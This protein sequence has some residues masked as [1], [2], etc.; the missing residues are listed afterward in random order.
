[1]T[2]EEHIE[3]ARKT[4][5]SYEDFSQKTGA[6]IFELKDTSP[7]SQDPAQEIFERILKQ[8]EKS[9]GGILP[10]WEKF[11]P[12]KDLTHTQAIISLQLGLLADLLVKP[13]L[14]ESRRAALQL[15]I[16]KI[17]HLGALAASTFQIGDDIA[18]NP[19]KGTMRDIPIVQETWNALQHDAK[20]DQWDDS[21]SKWI[22][23]Q[24]LDNLHYQDQTK[25]AHLIQTLD[26][27]LK[28]IGDKGQTLA[29]WAEKT[30]ERIVGGKMTSAFKEEIGLIKSFLTG[31]S[32]KEWGDKKKLLLAATV[33][34]SLLTPA[35]LA[36]PATL[37][38][39]GIIAQSLFS[40]AKEWREREIETLQERTQKMQ[41]VHGPEFSP[42]KEPWLQ[43]ILKAAQ[44]EGADISHPK[45]LDNG[46]PTDNIIIVG[47]VHHQKENPASYK[48]IIAALQKKG[49]RQITM[50]QPPE[51]LETYEEIHQSFP[52]TE[53]LD[54]YSQ[55]LQC[56]CLARRAGMT[57]Q[58]VDSPSKETDRNQKL[59]IEQMEGIV[60]TEGEPTDPARIS[61][62]L[63]GPK[64]ISQMLQRFDF[65]LG[66]LREQTMAKR[67]ADLA[68]KGPVAHF[69]GA[70][71]NAKLQDK[72]AT[73]TGRRPLSIILEAPSARPI[74]D[75]KHTIKI[76]AGQIADSL[77]QLF[78]APSKKLT[79]LDEQLMR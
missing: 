20:L 18:P 4:V 7:L 22:T 68:K 10:A 61:T 34:A 5:A 63:G 26:L 24:V 2:L 28:K 39:I 46:T 9:K 67:I 13:L 56:Y 78:A 74:S 76:P 35:F 16:Q 58:F 41:A 21:P 54:D 77:R 38:M 62:A 33:P 27:E 14:G 50:E 47:E 48:T 29:D 75:A 66:S 23:D 69:G 12:S 31:D 53:P 55:P 30:A 15:P 8:T 52:P 11:F 79:H 3:E 19:S 32:K 70:G 25:A 73:A 45:P 49:F 42:L 40:R 51:E 60:A 72:I 36:V 64:A 57:V 1:M 6:N 43:K 71:H 17:A 44:A 37:L 65:L 59:Y